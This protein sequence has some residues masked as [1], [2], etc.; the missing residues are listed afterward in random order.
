MAHT[1]TQLGQLRPANTTAA[2]LYAY[3]S[4]E[5]LVKTVVACNVSSDS[6]KFR[7]F[8][9]DSATTY[10][11]TTALYWDVEVPAGH[12]ANIEINA[13]MGGGNLAVRTDTNDAFNFT[14]YGS[15][16]S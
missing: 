16:V 9:D 8:H 2:S 14:A 6:A 10:D 5:V 12:S 7:V 15:V 11:E 3:V 1:M 13:M 4:G